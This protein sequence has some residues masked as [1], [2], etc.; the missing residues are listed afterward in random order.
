MLDTGDCQTSHDCSVPWISSL[1][2]ILMMSFSLKLL[3]ALPS[4]FF[5]VRWFSLRVSGSLIMLV[6]TSLTMIL[7]LLASLGPELLFPCLLLLSVFT[8]LYLSS[9]VGMVA[10][11][12]SHYSVT[13]FIGMVS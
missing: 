2:G 4:S 7:C 1:T 3:T 11:L 6:V 9:L 5:P 8:G 13:V 10:R 12:P